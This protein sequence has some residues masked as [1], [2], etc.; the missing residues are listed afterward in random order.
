MR[1]TRSVCRMPS[2]NGGVGGRWEARGHLHPKQGGKPLYR[3]S[4]VVGR[5]E[6]KYHVASM[7]R[8]RVYQDKQTKPT[9]RETTALCM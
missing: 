4:V 6:R 7:Y 1:F 9:T 3:E 5:A 2:E 8:Q